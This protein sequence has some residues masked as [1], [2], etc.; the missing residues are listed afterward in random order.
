MFEVGP[1]AVYLIDLKSEVLLIKQTKKDPKEGG[2]TSCWETLSQNR[3][4]FDK[5][6]TVLK[7]ICLLCYY[8]L[9]A[10]FVAH[11]LGWCWLTFDF[12]GRLKCAQKRK[13][14]RYLLVKGAELY[15]AAALGIMTST[16]RVWLT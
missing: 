8:V 5:S 2:D 1:C 9:N 15:L 16:K 3:E 4:L 7:L 14:T 6:E 12:V 10:V 13:M 11:G